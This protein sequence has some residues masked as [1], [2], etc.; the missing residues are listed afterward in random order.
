MQCQENFKV[1]ND[2]IHILYTEVLLAAKFPPRRPP[3]CLLRFSRQLNARVILTLR[4]SEMYATVG[5][6]IVCDRLQLYGILM[7]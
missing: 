2:S 3:C 1:W 7:Q 4:L 5:F 6:A